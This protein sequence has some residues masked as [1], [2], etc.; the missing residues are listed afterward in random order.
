MNY[1][2]FGTNILVFLSSISFGI[3]IC[4][5]AGRFI[6]LGN[7]L[8]YKSDSLVGYR[9]RPNQSNKRFKNAMV[10]TDSEGFR[11]NPSDKKDLSSEVFVFVGDSVTYGGSYIDDSELFSSIICANRSESICLNSGIN[12]WGT[13]N[14]GRFISNFSLYSNR[15][16]S[17]FILVILPGDAQRN[18]A[19]IRSL[20]FWTKPPKNPKAINEI[21]NYLLWKN[22][23][24]N[25]ETVDQIDLSKKNIIKYKTIQQSW[26]DLNNYLKSSKSKVNI[27]ITPPKRWFTNSKENQSD[28]DLN[29]KYLSKLSENPNVLK[30]CNLYTFIKDDYSKNDY[31]DSVHLSKSGHKKWAKYIKSCLNY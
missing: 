1:K 5:L 8:I 15:I 13:Y 27:V 31:V 23:I 4:E 16:P 19:D 25:K 9:L 21:I 18:L 29:D 6:G 24:S 2:R 7:P 14:M 10:S 30:T 11:I 20:P 28:I 17:E 22:V 3:L 12:A 26:D